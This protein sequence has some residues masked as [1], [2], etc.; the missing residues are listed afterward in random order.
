MSLKSDF[1]AGPRAARLSGPVS[2]GV[3][4]ILARSL[5]G[6][7]LTVEELARHCHSS[8]ACYSRR[9]KAETGQSP[10]AFARRVRLEESAFRLKV[11]PGRS[12][13]EIGCDCG[14]SPSNFSWA[15]RQQLGQSPA[16]FRREAGASAVRHPFCHLPKAGLAG[17]LEQNGGVQVQKMPELYVLCRRLIGNYHALGGVWADFMRACRPWRRPGSQFLVRSYDDPAITDPDA[18]LY[19]VCLTVP[20]GCGAPGVQRIP[21]GWY[22][23]LPYR[24]PVRNIYAAYQALFTLWL[25]G[26]GRRVDAQYSYDLYRQM[27]G[28]EDVLL[29]ICLPLQNA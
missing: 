20:P 6:E 9:F 21:G 3:D 25:P 8:A 11:E 14:Y 23:V 29:D 22:L 12:I 28:P 13:T 27:N 10:Y 16:R 17:L 26:S 2:R 5:A 7:P 4:Y 24:G 1:A 18:C 15:F 19:D